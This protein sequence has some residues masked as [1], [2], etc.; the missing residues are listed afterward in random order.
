[1]MEAPAI[2]LTPP[3]GAPDPAPMES[4]SDPRSASTQPPNVNAY[5][6]TRTVGD[7]GQQPTCPAAEHD[8]PTPT[9]ANP[10]AA[11]F[12]GRDDSSGLHEH[13][14]GLWA[15]AGL[16]HR[17]FGRRSGGRLVSAVHL[18]TP[19][20]RVEQANAL[21]TL[22]AR[23]PVSLITWSVFALLAL[24]GLSLVL[25]SAMLG[26]IL[27]IA[28]VPVLLAIAITVTTGLGQRINAWQTAA[29]RRHTLVVTNVAADPQGHGHGIALM[30]VIVSLADGL[31]RDLALIVN[32]ANH[33]AIRLYR[34][35]G[36]QVDKNITRRRTRMVR[37]PASEAAAPMRP[38]SW[39]VP[40]HVD[41][42]TVV[43]AVAVGLS[44]AGLYWGTPVV[45][46][47]VPVA[48]VAVIAAGNDLRTLRIPNRLVSVG[49][50]VVAV[51]IGVTSVATG[52]SLSWPAITGA[53]L[54]AGPLFVTHASAPGRSGL[55]DVKLAAI[56]G[57]VCGAV[58]PTAA[59]GALAVAMLLGLV[60][61][62][63]WRRR[64]QGGFPLA[65]A[66]AVGT[67]VVLALWAVLEGPT[68]W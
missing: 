49:T 33:A 53:A 28:L 61:S 30:A 23:D 41:T 12:D 42:L 4:A 40:I 36:F 58:Y 20:S 14:L 2:D 22:V 66:L 47:M 3:P 59:L 45:W 17:A 26:S 63:L 52:A 8:H 68:T 27:A 67:T 48:G 7:G 35:C 15:A 43:T 60:Y 10:V 29:G 50:A 16:H 9:R 56:L 34:S 21:A 55:G 38:P 6:S 46:L 44:L 32:P 64:R 65:P 19:S 5:V 18:L 39:L 1:M 31:G 51:T 62:L 54:F 57:L 13:P 24:G 11:R 25:A 37:H